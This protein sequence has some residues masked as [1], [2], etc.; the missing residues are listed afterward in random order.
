MYGSKIR[1][2]LF[3]NRFELYVPGALANTITLDSLDQRQSSRN[4]TIASL[5]AKC[6]VPSAISDLETTRSTLMDRRGEGV[7]IILDR[8]ERLSGR[9]PVYELPDQSE[10]KL[11]V[12]A[13][14][15]SLSQ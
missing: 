3:S 4:E 11:T 1:M 5:L 14:S 9:R 15:I 12:F 2:R 8:S 10:V 13:A 6:P 7:S